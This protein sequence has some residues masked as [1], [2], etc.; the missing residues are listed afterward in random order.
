EVHLFV[1]SY[2][3]TPALCTNLRDGTFRDD[4][5]KVGIEIE[6]SVTSVAAADFNK[7]DFTDFFFG[8]A[9]ARGV[10]AISDGRGRFRMAPAPA[11][12][13]GA[14]AAQF[15]DYDND[16]MLDPLTGSADGSRLPRASVGHWS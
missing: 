7:D 9:S 1:A 6:G 15:V 12:T 16:G 5:S 8:R 10:F 13:A 14:L 3:G 4:A 2:G 11:A